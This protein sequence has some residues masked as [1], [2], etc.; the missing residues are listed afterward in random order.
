MQGIYAI[1]CTATGEQYIGKALHI[2][3]RWS[4]HEHLMKSGRHHSQRLAEA[5]ATYGPTAFTWSVLELVE[6]TNALLRVEREYLRRLRPA[7]N[8]RGLKSPRQRLAEMRAANRAAEAAG[9]IW[10]TEAVVKFIHSRSWFNRR[11]EAGLF[12]IESIP[13]FNKVYL[14]RKEID[15]YIVAHPD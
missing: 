11:I 5:W 12:H 14:W 9:G 3:R 10:I 1:T 2:F 6:D 7:F 15:D 8:T 4:Q 13:G